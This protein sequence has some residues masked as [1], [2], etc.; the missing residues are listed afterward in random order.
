[1]SILIS[2]SVLDRFNPLFEGAGILQLADKGMTKGGIDTVTPHDDFRII[3]PFN[4]RY[5]ELSRD[6]RNRAF[7]RVINTP[8]R[9][10]RAL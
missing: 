6:M 5:E 4:P 7:Q 10:L 9:K 2:A 8:R 3:F 1:M